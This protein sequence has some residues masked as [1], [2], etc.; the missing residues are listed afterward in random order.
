METRCERWI[1]DRYTGFLVNNYYV[2]DEHSLQELA[3]L[4]K[5][6]VEETS[7]GCEVFADSVQQLL[8]ALLV[9]GKDNRKGIVGPLTIRCTPMVLASSVIAAI[10]TALHFVPGGAALSLAGLTVLSGNIATAAS[11]VSLLDTAEREILAVALAEHRLSGDGSWICADLIAE[12]LAAGYNRDEV[13]AVLHTLV[14]KDAIAWD[15]SG[16]TEV[17]MKKWL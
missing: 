5:H 10:S 6:E 14:D 4:V 17:R 13:F 1:R 7:P 2:I 3:M 16:G 15:G 9:Q 11:A 8:E 12:R